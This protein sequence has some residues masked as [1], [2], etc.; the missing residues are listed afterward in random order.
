MIIPES[1]LNS[2]ESNIIFEVAGAV[3]KIGSS[4]KPDHLYKSPLQI[5][6]TLLITQH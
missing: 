2:F 4:L 5:R 6:E 3:V 1:F